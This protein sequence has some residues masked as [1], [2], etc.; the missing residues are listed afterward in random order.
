MKLKLVGLIMVT[1]MMTLIV[2]CS[3][4]PTPATAAQAP[5][6]SVPPTSSAKVYTW[7]LATNVGASPTLWVFNDWKWF[8]QRVFDATKGRLVL[9]VKIDLFPGTQTIDGVIRGDAEIGFQRTPWVSGT[10][11]LW[12]FASLPFFW[13]DVLEY[14]RACQ[15]P[16]MEDII[17]KSSNAVGLVKMA[18]FAA[19]NIDAIFAKKAIP[20][21]NDWKGLKVRT[22]GALPTLT[23]QLLGGSPLSIGT[24][25]ISDAISKGTVDAVQTS[26]Y[27]GLALGMADVCKFV[28]NWSVQS[29]FGGIVIINKKAWNTLP[30]DMQAVLMK[31]G[32][33]MTR[34][35][36]VGEQAMYQYSGTAL[37]LSGVKVTQPDANEIDKARR[38]AKPVIDKWLI[39]AGPQGK[40]V[41]NIAA[42]YASGAKVMLAK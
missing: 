7:T 21:V 17:Q 41:L 39:L 25:E 42:D 29:S 26:R 37:Q 22:T 1:V 8:Q 15:D 13:K 34:E 18:E 24:T 20:T 33:E 38:L 11:P 5:S 35:I 3:Q 32:A 30:S 14:T 12:D 2:V 23:I 19:G 16:R 40:D 10:Y 9:N 36:N 27:Y 4:T 31:V 6:K 28:S